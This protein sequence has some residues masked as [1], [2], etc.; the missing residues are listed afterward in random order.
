[1]APAETGERPEQDGVVK[2]GRIPCTE[3]REKRGRAALQAPERNPRACFFLGP[4][5]RVGTEEAE[6]KDIYWRPDR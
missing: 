1:M 3:L 2:A 6:K 4:F 5:L